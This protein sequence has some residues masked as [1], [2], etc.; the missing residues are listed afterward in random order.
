MREE[1]GRGVEGGGW[2]GGGG[3]FE[4]IRKLEGTAGLGEVKKHNP[5]CSVHRL[6]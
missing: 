4:P 5:V 6:V 3:G 2:W 1:S